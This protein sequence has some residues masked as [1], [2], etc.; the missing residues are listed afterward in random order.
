M[1]WVCENWP[2]TSWDTK[3]PLISQSCRIWHA[4]MLRCLNI[5]RNESFLKSGSSLHFHFWKCTKES[6]IG[7]AGTIVVFCKANG[8]RHYEKNYDK[9]RVIKNIESDDFWEQICRKLNFYWKMY[10]TNV[11]EYFSLQ[12]ATYHFLVIDEK[13]NWGS[14]LSRS[15]W[16]GQTRKGDQYLLLPTSPNTLLKRKKCLPPKHAKSLG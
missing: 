4:N 5:F 16:S 2:K 13:E 12:R 15:P 3:T 6:C 7:S 14:H 9:K 10:A 8:R 1:T 11:V